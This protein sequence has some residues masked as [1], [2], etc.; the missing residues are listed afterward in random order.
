MCVCGDPD[1]QGPGPG[2]TRGR[3]NVSVFAFEVDDL[4]TAN[5]WVSLVYPS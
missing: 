4:H 2:G 1:T 5:S 3:D